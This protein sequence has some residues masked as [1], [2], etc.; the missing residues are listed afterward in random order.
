M[1]VVPSCV[2]LSKTVIV[3]SASRRAVQRHRNVPA[4][5]FTV[6]PEITGAAG[7]EVLGAVVMLFVTVLLLD[8]FMKI[9]ASHRRQ[10]VL[11]VVS[12]RRYCR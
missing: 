6:S 9:W 4:Y 1:V 2:E 10:N 5:A 7:G 8:W 12:I 3:L 11:C